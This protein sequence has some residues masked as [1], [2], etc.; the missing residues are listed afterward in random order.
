MGGAA[1]GL[2]LQGIGAL[3]ALQQ[4]QQADGHQAG[5]VEV[6]SHDPL[7]QAGNR[8]RGT[9]AAVG[10]PALHLIEAV[11]PHAAA[12]LLSL[13]AQGR[14]FEAV[15]GAQGVEQWFTLLLGAVALGEAVEHLGEPHGEQAVGLETLLV[16]EQMQLHQQFIHQAPVER[17]DHVGESGVKG[18]LAVGNGEAGAHAQGIKVGR[19]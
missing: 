13:C 12:R 15:G 11:M 14:A 19:P 2:R 10:E 16:A 7:Q 17:R 3:G 5:I 18:P 1:Q 9:L 6:R 8:C 4:A